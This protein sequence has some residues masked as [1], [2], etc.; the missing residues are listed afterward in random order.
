MPLT[1]SATTNPFLSTPPNGLLLNFVPRAAPTFAVDANGNLNR[2]GPIVGAVGPPAP[3]P[4]IGGGPWTV[5]VGVVG[6]RDV[7]IAPGPPNTGKGV[8]VAP[9]PVEAFSLLFRSSNT[10]S[11]EG[12]GDVLR[13]IGALSNPLGIADCVSGTL[14]EGGNDFLFISS[15]GERKLEE[16]SGSGLSSA[17]R[18]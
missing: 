18:G 15:P 17:K 11:K 1:A 5:I 2:L 14:A 16:R 7:V 6:R 9:D 12:A 13:E 8:S 10:A 4:M 3:E